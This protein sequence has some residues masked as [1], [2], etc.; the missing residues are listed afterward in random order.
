MTQ[1]NHVIARYVTLHGS[2]CLLLLD[3][4]HGSLTW[5]LHVFRIFRTR[6][7]MCISIEQFMVFAAEKSGYHLSARYRIIV[8]T[9][10]AIALLID[11]RSTSVRYNVPE[12]LCPRGQS[13]AKPRLFYVSR[14]E[15]RSTPACGCSHGNQARVINSFAYH[16]CFATDARHSKLRTSS[17][18][19]LPSCTST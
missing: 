18:G 15:I 11:Q 13:D 4:I 8:W 19:R 5:P 16:K 10:E 9:L 6:K 17:A 12:E 1:E 3:C 7:Y 2:L 14:C